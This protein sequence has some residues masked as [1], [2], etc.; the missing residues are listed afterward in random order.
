M[1]ES[2]GSEIRFFIHRVAAAQIAEKFSKVIYQEAMQ[3]TT[4]QT[5]LLS[6]AIMV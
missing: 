2:L 4:K 1:G 3:R 6:L 5:T